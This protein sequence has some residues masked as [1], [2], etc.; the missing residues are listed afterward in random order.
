[1]NLVF[2]T[3]EFRE[4]RLHEIGKKRGEVQQDGG[5]AGNL[6]NIKSPWK[7]LKYSDFYFVLFIHLNTV[8]CLFFSSRKW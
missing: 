8:L 4:E 3:G 6:I 2:R 1:M 5:D 7:A